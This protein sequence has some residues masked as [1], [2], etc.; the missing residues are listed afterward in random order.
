MDSRKAAFNQQ[1]NDVL[2]LNFY[3]GAVAE[4]GRGPSIWDTFSKNPGN[5]AN[6]EN[7]DV[8]CDHYHRYKDDIALMKDLGITHYR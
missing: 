2:Y 6:D 1:S 4:D 3:T 8:A 7:G 5:I